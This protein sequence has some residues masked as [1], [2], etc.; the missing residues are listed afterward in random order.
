M[1]HSTVK[2]VI[3]TLE[4]LVMKP[5]PHRNTP[6]PVLFHVRTS[7][8]VIQ[9]VLQGPHRIR[10]YSGGTVQRGARVTVVASV[11]GAGVGAPYCRVHFG[12]EQPCEP[13]PTRPSPPRCVST[14][15]QQVVL[16]LLA[17]HLRCCLGPNFG[18][19]WGLCLALPSHPGHKRSSSSL[20]ASAFINSLYCLNHAHPNLHL[21]STI[22]LLSP[23]IGGFWQFPHPRTRLHT[24]Q[25]YPYLLRPSV[26]G[27]SSATNFPAQHGWCFFYSALLFIVSST[28][29]PIVPSTTYTCCGCSLP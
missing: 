2:L 13:G 14:L 4:R 9:R 29:I 5:R 25:L 27:P 28:R 24:L 26:G 23:A 8:A 21:S 17:W 1:A 6:A 18:C 11:N 16:A 20:D 3:G 19:S 15:T 22:W 12:A 7:V 10:T